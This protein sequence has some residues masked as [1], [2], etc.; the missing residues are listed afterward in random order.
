MQN[1]TPKNRFIFI[2]FNAGKANELTPDCQIRIE[3]GKKIDGQLVYVGKNTA[4]MKKYFNNNHIIELNNCC[5]TIGNIREIKKF[6]ANYKNEK[7]EIIIIS[8]NYHLR[9]IIYIMNEFNLSAQLL[10]AEKIL[11][12]K[13]I[14]CPIEILRLLY[15][16]LVI[17]IYELH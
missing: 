13:A 10:S 17:K 11:G 3:A 2:L 9:R 6:L 7:S 15:T 14:I 5:D 12:L 8:N 4:L 1:T 16:F